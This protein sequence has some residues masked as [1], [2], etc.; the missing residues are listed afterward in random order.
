MQGD[1]EQRVFRS[2]PATALTLYAEGGAVAFF[3]GW[4]WRTSRMIMAIFI[5][6][7]CK[8]ILT[9]ILFPYKFKDK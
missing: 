4:S 5:M 1:V 7:Q 3:R 8:D 6:G 2:M 9:P